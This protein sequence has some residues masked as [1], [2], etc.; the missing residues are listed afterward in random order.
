MTPPEHDHPA[1]P[2]PFPIPADF[3]VTWERPDQVGHFWE[4]ESLH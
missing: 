4:Q 3:P 1:A 2:Q